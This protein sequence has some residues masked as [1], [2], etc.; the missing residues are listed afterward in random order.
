MGAVLAWPHLVDVI[1]RVG[2]EPMQLQT[3]D[4]VDLGLPVRVWRLRGEGPPVVLVH[5]LLT[6]P[7]VLDLAPGSSL[8]EALNAR[9]F[10]VWV[11]DLASA[12][13]RW[14]IDPVGPGLA[15]WARLLRR[16]DEAVSK[17]AGARVHIVGYCL[18]ATISVARLARWTDRHVASL[19]LIAPVVDT[20]VDARD[21]H[22]MGRLLG[23]RRLHPALVLDEHGRVPGV[24]VREA[25]HL[26][27]PRALRTVFGYRR[28]HRDPMARRFY[29]AMMRWTWEHRP[30]DGA[31]FADL[32]AL[33]RANT[34][35]RRRLVID[36]QPVDLGCLDLATLVITATNDHIVPVGSSTA[37]FDV[38]AGR[39]HHVDTGSGH[40]AMLVGPPLHEVVVPA[41]AAHVERHA[42]VVTSGAVASGAVTSGAVASRAVTSGAVTSGTLTAAS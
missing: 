31:T 11:V 20:S 42:E 39:G 37:L 35:V 40:V 8:A 28:V 23:L 7:W 13:D 3:R 16:V 34:L 38:M 29:G 5:S 1:R 14:T 27:R 15:R 33:Y 25:F 17:A 22:G 30:L 9:G 21:G 24:A 6:Q 4:L 41:I 32:L 18:G 19:S 26:L 10:D 12:A 2:R 36:E